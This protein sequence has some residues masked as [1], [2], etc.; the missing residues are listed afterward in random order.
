MC[1]RNNYSFTIFTNS[2]IY[3]LK[4]LAISKKIKNKLR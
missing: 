2:I 4:K 3:I 1:N